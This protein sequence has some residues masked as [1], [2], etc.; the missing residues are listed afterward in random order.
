M[1]R[2][3]VLSRSAVAAATLLAAGCSSLPNGQVAALSTQNR[4]LIEQNRAH[5]AEI[6]NLR[7]HSRNIEDQLM[8]AEED[9]ALL[10]ERL[11]LDGQRLTN[12]ERERSGLYDHLLTASRNGPR[13]APG[14][15]RELAEL[16][17]RYPSLHFDPTTGIAKLDTDVLFDSGDAEPK[18]AARA[19]VRELARVLNDPAAR[20]LRV[21]VAG[22]TDD[23]QVAG[24]GVREQHPDNLHL[25]TARALAVTE[26]LRAA[27]VGA[28]RVAVAGFGGH[29]P[30]APND[31]P[32]NRLVNRRVEIF[33]MAPEVPVVGWTETIPSLY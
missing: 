13:L 6:E 23:R 33:V 25:S 21:F 9:L 26:E 17:E 11:D 24:R 1:R 18:A 12:Y 16:A 8:R 30:I 14:V 31:S 27:G 28:S 19:V 15:G 7:I 3:I 32:S 10:G 22:H 29:Q 5:V 2:V 4:A 20:T